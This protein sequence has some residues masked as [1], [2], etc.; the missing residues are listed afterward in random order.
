MALPSGLKP[1]VA[2]RFSPLLYRPAGDCT[3]SVLPDLQYRMVLAVATMDS[4]M[5]Y[6]TEVRTESYADPGVWGGSTGSL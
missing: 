4:V 5:L 6:E 1:V 2:V 3:A